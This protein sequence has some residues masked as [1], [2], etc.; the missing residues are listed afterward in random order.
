ML[1]NIQYIKRQ[2]DK[3]M[4]VRISQKLIVFIE[5]RIKYPHF[6]KYSFLQ[7]E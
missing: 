5:I 1:H 2:L 7:D 6:N 4:A 3:A